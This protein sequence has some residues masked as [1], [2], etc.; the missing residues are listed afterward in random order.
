MSSDVD[1][2][3]ITR[4]WL[5]APAEP[6]DPRDIRASVL[7]GNRRLS[8]TLLAEYC[9]GAVLVGIAAWQLATREGLDTFVWGFALLCF[10]AMALQFSTWNRRGLWRPAAESTR[11]YLDLA[12]ERVWRRERAVRFAW[13]LFGLEFVFL[14]AWYPLTWFLWPEQSWTLLERTPRMA[15]ALGLVTLALI[16]WS[17]RSM[18]LAREERCELERLRSDLLDVD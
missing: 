11:D 4:A 10:T 5:D 12:L 6:Q 18:Q 14:L 3:A 13:L 2:E 8:L 1:W 17:I 15:A 7:A 9:V 16:G